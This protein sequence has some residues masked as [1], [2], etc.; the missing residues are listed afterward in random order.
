MVRYWILKK[1]LDNLETASWFKPRRG[2]I[3]H[4]KRNKH[5]LYMRSAHTPSI[6]TN[7]KEQSF[8]KLSE[9]VKTV[10]VESGNQPKNPLLH[11]NSFKDT[12]VST[13]GSTPHLL[14]KNSKKHPNETFP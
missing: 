10:E 5:V 8:R 2:K 4:M 12:R 6:W 7:L 11:M 9:A 14:R 13:Y 3:K 1:N